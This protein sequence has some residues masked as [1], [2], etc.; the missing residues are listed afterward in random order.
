MRVKTEMYLH[1]YE[2]A[3]DQNTIHVLFPVKGMRRYL[4]RF[5]LYTLRLTGTVY[6]HVHYCLS[7]YHI[8]HNVFCV[9][10]LDI[11]GN[12]VCTLAA[13]LPNPL[14]PPAYHC[15]YMYMFL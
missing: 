11:I 8:S 2:S 9:S 6:T 13:I 15:T 12:V 1:T 3:C 10:Y 4:N 5:A 14:F 7:T